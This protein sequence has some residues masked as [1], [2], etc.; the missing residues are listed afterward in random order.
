VSVHGANVNYKVVEGYGSLLLGGDEINGKPIFVIVASF[1]LI[2]GSLN[3]DRQVP[4]RWK[5]KTAIPS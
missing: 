3:D 4:I 1:G 5:R 2:L